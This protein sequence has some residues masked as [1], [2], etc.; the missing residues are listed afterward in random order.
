MERWCHVGL[1]VSDLD[2]SIAFYHT[3][4]SL[5]F[6]CATGYLSV[7]ELDVALRVTGAVLGRVNFEVGDC[8]LLELLQYRGPASL[9][10]RALPC[11]AAESGHVAFLVDDS[12][13]RK[14][15]LEARGVE[16]FS[17]ID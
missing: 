4:L 11:N 17:D 15:E 9:H 8:G 1:A 16:V 12:A 6:A 13:A 10:K 5:E 7:P 14:A 3:A 2:Q